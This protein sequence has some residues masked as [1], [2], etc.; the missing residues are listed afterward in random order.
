L[1]RT[2]TQEAYNF[3]GGFATGGHSSKSASEKMYS[4]PSWFTDSMK[5]VY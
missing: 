2:P 1:Q 4:G 3:Y 5:D